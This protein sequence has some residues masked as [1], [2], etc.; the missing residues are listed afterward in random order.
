MMKCARC[1]RPLAK[2]FATLAGMP[3]GPKCAAVVGAAVHST[4]LETAA[5]RRARA[6][7]TAREAEFNAR[8]LTLLEA[9]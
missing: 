9:T 7:V 8:Q 5:D 1:H 3:F 6:A 2:A 4:P